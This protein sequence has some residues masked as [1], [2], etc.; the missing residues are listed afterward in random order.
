MGLFSPPASH[1]HLHTQTTESAVAASPPRAAC[2]MQALYRLSSDLRV[3]RGDLL[4]LQVVHL[5]NTFVFSEVSNGLHNS[6]KRLVK[7][8][9]V[10]CVNDVQVYSFRNDLFEEKQEAVLSTK[11]LETEYLL[12]KITAKSQQPPR[13]KRGKKQKSF[14][15]FTVFPVQ[16]FQ[17][18]KFMIQLD[19][20]KQLGML[21]Q[22]PDSTALMPGTEAGRARRE[23]PLDEYRITCPQ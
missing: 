5:S 14:E 16:V 17:M 20:G 10:N 6:H 4:R 23:L 1:R 13:K 12:G 3:Q 8:I 21:Y 15:A 9:A 7:F 22:L 11:E 18:F 19:S 2:W